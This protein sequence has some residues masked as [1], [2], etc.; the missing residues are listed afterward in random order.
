MPKISIA[1][2]FCFSFILLMMMNVSGNSEK[3]T[4]FIPSICFTGINVWA[5]DADPPGEVP[6]GYC[7]ASATCSSDSYLDAVGCYGIDSCYAINFEFAACDGVYN[8]C[9]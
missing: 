1:L 6:I 9:W 3:S 4:A 8:W 5:S 7:R 2:F